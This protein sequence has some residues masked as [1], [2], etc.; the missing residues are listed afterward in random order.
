MRWRWWWWTRV[1][2]SLSRTHITKFRIFNPLINSSFPYGTGRYSVGWH[3]ELLPI[4]CEFDSTFIHALLSIHSNISVRNNSVESLSSK[5]LFFLLWPSTVDC[6]QGLSLQSLSGRCEGRVVR[7]SFRCRR[8]R[9]IVC[10]GKLAAAFDV[11][12]FWNMCPLLI[13]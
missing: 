11:N 13:K 6:T 1:V 3:R 4:K 8:R 10:S 9:C 12:Y 5:L 2:C 7:V